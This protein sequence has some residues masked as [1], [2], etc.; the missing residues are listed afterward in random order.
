MNL[1]LDVLGQ[2]EGGPKRRR[3]SPSFPGELLHG[4]VDV[5][6]GPREQLGLLRESSESS[7]G[8]HTAEE[9]LDLEVA[10]H[11]DS[12]LALGHLQG[13]LLKKLQ[14]VVNFE[15]SGVNEAPGQVLASELHLLGPLLPERDLG[16]TN[17]ECAIAVLDAIADGLIVVFGASDLDI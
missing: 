9:R 1:R 17:M 8:P 5:L 13:D 2:E 4:L 11:V 3:F 6:H 10:P 12:T 14:E 15:G 7:M 16:R